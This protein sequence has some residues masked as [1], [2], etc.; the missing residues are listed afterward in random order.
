M[1]KKGR[2]PEYENYTDV[3]DI[4]SPSYFISLYNSKLGCNVANTIMFLADVTFPFLVMV[5]VWY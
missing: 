4:V 2:C 3:V 5:C 1:K